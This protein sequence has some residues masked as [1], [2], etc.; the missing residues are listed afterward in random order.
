MITKTFNKE[1]LNNFILSEEFSNLE[2]LPISFHRA[3]SQINNPRLDDSDVILCAAFDSNKTVGYLGVIPDYIFVNNEK[4]KMG[5]L[6][7]FWVDSNYKNSNIAANLFLRIIRAWNKKIMI[8]NFI[9]PLEKV[10]QKTKIFNQ[11]Q[12]R[13]G[14]RSYLKFNLAEVLPQKHVFFA[15]NKYAL[16]FI[17]LSLNFLLL[18]TFKLFSN[19]LKFN[20][21]YKLA[22]L[23]DLKLQ[24]FISKSNNQNLSKRNISEL[25]WIL[26]FPWV[27]EQEQ[28]IDSKKYFFTS[29]SSVFKTFAYEVYNSKNGLVGFFVFNQRETHLTVPYFYVE[30]DF[31]AD[32]VTFLI[33][34]MKTNNCCMLTSFNDN[35]NLCLEEN[36]KQFI[37]QKEIKKLYLTSKDIKEIDINNFEAGDG[38]CAFY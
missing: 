29:V 4:I 30:K 11:T 37:F 15:K 16:S 18:N 2:N 33:N 8:T 31:Q 25:K 10:Y 1:Q 14:L 9:S 13:I 20:C 6:S 5:W 28:N 22:N 17:D 7:C 3:I 23:E 36:R 24:N 19:N 26:N 27:L 12:T 34:Y 32:V 35:L 21:K 38:D